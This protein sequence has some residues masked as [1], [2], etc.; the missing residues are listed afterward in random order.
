[1]YR[2]TRPIPLVRTAMAQSS[3]CSQTEIKLY[4]RSI[5]TKLQ[6]KKSAYIQKRHQCPLGKEHRFHI[7]VVR[8]KKKVFLCSNTVVRISYWNKSAEGGQFLLFPLQYGDRNI[9]E[10]FFFWRRTDIAVQTSKTA[11]SLSSS[12]KKG[13]KKIY[14]REDSETGC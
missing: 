4:W 9:S 3:S 5:Y 2:Q 7:V 8:K 13:K 1:M 6:H 11:F 10:C 12:I 14:F